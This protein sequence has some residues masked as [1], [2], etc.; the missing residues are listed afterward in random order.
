[1][2]NDF[3]DLLNQVFGKR[4]QINTANTSLPELHAR[5]SGP[6]R[7]AAAAR[8][9]KS[10]I[11]TVQKNVLEMQKNLEARAAQQRQEIEAL[12]QNALADINRIEQELE[13][14]EVKAL[15]QPQRAKTQKLTGLE[16]FDGLF[17]FLQTHVFGQDEYLRQLCIALKR[18]Y[19]M[20]HSGQRSR[21]AIFIGGPSCTGR[22]LALRQAATFL[23][24]KNVFVSANI[25][26][27]DLALYPTS[28]EEKLF[29]QDLYMALAGSCDLVVF[30]NSA[31]CHPGFL[32]VLSNLVQKGA[33]P[34]ANRYVLQNGRLVDAG[35]SLVK[36]AVS[37]L[38]PNGKYLFFCENT[39]IQKLAD[40][41]GGPFVSALSDQ[42]QTI[43]LTLQ[44]KMEIARREQE[45]L[46]T[47]AHETLDF[48]VTVEPTVLSLACE[49]E[50]ND[51]GAQPLLTFFEQL[52]HALAQY[53]LEH[54]LAKELPVLIDASAGK[55][56]I[57]F[58]EIQANLS[59]LL[60]ADYRGNV[61]EVKEE[62]RQI[63]GLENVKEYIL[64]LEENFSVQKRRESLGLKTSAV[65]MHMIFTGNPGTGKTTIARLVS[66]YLKAI[67]I[68]S[69][70]QLVEVTRADLVGK[71][72]GH[73]AP[74]TTQVLNSALG[75]V[76]FID[77]AYSLYR[78]KDDSFGLECIDTL[79]KGME[80]HRDDL[81]VILAGYTREM[82]EF[83][84]AN[85]GLKSR[86]PN[87]IEFPDYTG[88]ELV[89]IAQLQAK[90]KGYILDEQCIAP[91]TIYFNAVQLT[92]AREAGNGRLA[93][94][95]V[96]EAILTQSR[97]VAKDLSADLSVLL[98]E[99][100]DLED[101][102]Q[103][104]KEVP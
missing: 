33:H 78:G 55:T 44:A 63:V 27:M 53:K 98:L 83:L 64:S 65:S 58:G 87:I 95:K 74:L 24:Q 103:N 11:D 91:L 1:M 47:R 30:L 43:P 49:H 71:Y 4:G 104:E 60:P 38:T 50:K 6:K 57:R 59:D 69:G 93:R 56:C 70:G 94:N 31:E 54:E 89:A 12:N 85:S 3:D 67:G 36:E 73:T 79:V 100:F 5:P 84:Q 75:G 77:E 9:K 13:K 23:S 61:E 16:G 41:F 45:L 66:K 51:P 15:A 102:A 86:F 32:T 18:P 2:K 25:A 82:N 80:D 26:W 35:A 22:K 14:P 92:H 52:Y 40:R 42:C 20:G 72:V 21:G 28:A 19:V 101:V 76:L 97:R 10:S 96:E 39:N 8:P 48:C 17:E 90:S 34:L 81:V 29:L 88:E 99:D 37:Q 46:I 68:L 7:N 62:L